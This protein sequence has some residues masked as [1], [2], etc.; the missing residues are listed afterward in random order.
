M[1]RITTRTDLV[2]LARTL[3]VRKDWHEPDE[4]DV[5]AQVWG[6]SFDNAGFWPLGEHTMHPESLEQHVILWQ[7][8]NDEEYAVNLATLFAWATGYEAPAS[9]PEVDLSPRELDSLKVQQ[10]RSRVN[11]L[12][13]LL[14]SLRPMVQTA[15]EQQWG[16]ILRDFNNL[17]PPK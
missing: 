10:L 14:M 16:L 9:T 5:N 15:S 11:V 12:E 7:D 2:E 3:G 1:R 4:Q 17:F 13:E 6:S 8:G